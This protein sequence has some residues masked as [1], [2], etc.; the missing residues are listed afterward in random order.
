ML[1]PTEL[2]LVPP[3]VSFTLGGMMAFAIHYV[4]RLVSRRDINYNGHKHDQMCSRRGERQTFWD[5]RNAGYEHQLPTMR[6]MVLLT[7]MTNISRKR[8]DPKVKNTKHDDVIKWN[9]SALL[10]LCKGNP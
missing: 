9:K 4:L 2:V 7:W 5:I 8:L 3:G 6:Q 10:A 1:E